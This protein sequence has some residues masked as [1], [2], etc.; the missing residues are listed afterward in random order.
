[1][2]KKIIL[3]L[4]MSLLVMST[5]T[6]CTKDEANFYSLVNEVN[7]LKSLEGT[8]TVE[9]KGKGLLIDEMAKELPEELKGILKGIEFKY[10]LKQN[11]KTMETNV[12]LE[13][14]YIGEKKYVPFTEVILKNDKTYIKADDLIK[15]LKP[16]I[17]LQDP[18]AE[19]EL[20]NIIEKVRYVNV[21]DSSDVKAIDNPELVYKLADIVKQAFNDMDLKNVV[22]RNAINSYEVTIDTK[23]FNELF[24]EIVSYIVKN[25]DKVFDT[26]IDG[27]DK[28]SDE[29]IKDLIKMSGNSVK[30]KEEI[31]NNIKELKEESKAAEVIDIGEQLKSV[32]GSKIVYKINKEKNNYNISTAFHINV[33]GFLSLS[34][35]ENFNIK[36]ARNLHINAPKQTIT[37]ESFTEMLEKTFNKDDIKI[38]KIPNVN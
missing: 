21:D 12:K 17:L 3:V 9:V 22:K 1:M 29:E 18:K 23:A 25:N 13:A 6:G 7:N 8:G 38:D 19:I 32:E 30:T 20:N 34:L 5:I 33:N 2:K 27:I 35:K 16:Y 36:P 24:Q 28:L 4:V 15:F 26:I 37:S 31:I 14:R 10:T 11:K